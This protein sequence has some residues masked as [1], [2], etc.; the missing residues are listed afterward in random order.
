MTVFKVETL[1]SPAT[2]H[3]LSLAVQEE[4]RVWEPVPIGQ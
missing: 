1:Q 3:W 4:Q 2:G